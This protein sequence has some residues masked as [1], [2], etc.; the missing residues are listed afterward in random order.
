VKR[1][2]RLCNAIRAIYPMGSFCLSGIS[3]DDKSNDLWKGTVTVGDAIL[4]ETTGSVDTV[5]LELTRKL[6]KMSQRMLAQLSS[7]APPA[8][9]GDP[10]SS[11]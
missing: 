4:L 3:G 8:G 10:P 5:V 7:S 6:E 9:S 1:L 11:R 2:L